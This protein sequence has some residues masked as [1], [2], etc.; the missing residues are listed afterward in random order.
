[1]DSLMTA[2]A[3]ALA[4]GDPL[5]ALNRVA[6]RDDAPALALRGIAMAQLGDLVR[7]KA[8]VRSA[9]RAFGAREPVARARCVVAEAE[10]ALVSRDLN[11]PTKT[12]EAAR[13]TLEA[14]G[15]RLNAAHARYL[16]VRRLLLIAR[17][18]EAERALAGLDPTPFPPALRAAHE[19]VVAGVALRRLQTRAARA[20]LERARRAAG[21]AGIPALIAEV[22]NAALV[23]NTPAARLIARAE[24]RPLLLDEVEALLASKA[25]IVDA[26]R[27]VIRE[28]GAV[29]SLAG[30]PVLF[31]LARALAEAWPED[32]PRDV[33]VARAFRAKVADESH[34]ARLRVELGRLRSVLRA[35]AGVSATR[36]GF[37]LMPRHAQEVVVLARP[38]EDRHAPVLALLADGESWSSSALAL[39]LGA[40]QRTVQRSLDTLAVQGKVQSVGKGRARRWMTPPMPGFTTTLLLPAPLPID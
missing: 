6:L 32:V 11:W 23:L 26:C 33:L 37:M 29:I 10:I 39:A 35:V 15:D 9:A 27:H 12:L 19:L 7:A 13:V 24:E 36:R 17:L 1:M 34:R 22:D 3:R 20:A 28:T 31:V 38:V 30:R 25:L 14:H 21:L 5:G 8:L 4:A 18:D 2:A 40:S 16:E